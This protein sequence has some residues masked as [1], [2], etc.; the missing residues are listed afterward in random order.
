[1]VSQ[2][3]NFGLPAPIDVQVSGFN[4]DANRDYADALL[5]KHARHSRRGRP[6]H[7][8]GLRLPADQR[9]RRSQQGGA[10]RPVRAGRGLES[11]GVALGELPDHALVLDRPAKTARST[12]SRPRLRSSRS[13]RS[14]TWPPRRSPRRAAAPAAARRLLANL[15]SFHRSVVPAVVSHYD[16]T[17][18]IDIYGSSTAPTSASS[19]RRST[20]WWPPPAMS[21]RAA[22]RSRC[23]ARSR[24]M[25]QS[26][27]GLLL[28]L[29]GAVVLVYLLIVVNFQSWLDPVHHHHGAAGG[30]GRD[31]LDAVPHAHAR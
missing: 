28:G 30:A 15:A 23:A 6:A 25:T 31:R 1:M 26:F 4:V 20:S 8:A 27:S 17:P 5:A 24:T 29:A 11:P 7:P 2:I 16:A 21:C 10:A 3:L 9:G 12:A 19:P 13:L 14:R 22:R 18:V